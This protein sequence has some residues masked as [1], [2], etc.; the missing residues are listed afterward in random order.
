M[1]VNGW[2]AIVEKGSFL[3]GGCSGSTKGGRVPCD[4]YALDT[5]DLWCRKLNMIGSRSRVKSDWKFSYE[6]SLDAFAGSTFLPK[7][8]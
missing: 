3:V 4:T 2:L 7:E 8:D 6:M 1:C 5:G